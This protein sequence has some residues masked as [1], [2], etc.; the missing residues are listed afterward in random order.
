MD[1]YNYSWT[2]TLSFNKTFNKHRIKAVAGTEFS[3]KIHTFL[4]VLTRIFSL[5]RITPISPLKRADENDQ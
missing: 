1:G 3:E 4:Q 5:I 2:N